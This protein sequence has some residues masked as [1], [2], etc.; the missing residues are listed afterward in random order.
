MAVHRGRFYCGHLS[1][2]K[3]RLAILGFGE[4]ADC[5]NKDM[6]ILSTIPLA[7]TISPLNPK[8]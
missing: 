8:C 4:G 5:C 3:V 7:E 2:A 1:N 6:T